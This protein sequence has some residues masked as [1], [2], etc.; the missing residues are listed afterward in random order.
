MSVNTGCKIYLDDFTVF[1]MKLSI[2]S[3]DIFI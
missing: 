3:K 2:M 1:E